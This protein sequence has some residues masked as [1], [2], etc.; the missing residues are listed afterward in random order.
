M[1]KKELLFT[2]NWEQGFVHTS[3]R[4]GSSV[5]LH[6]IMLGFY[7]TTT[8]GQTTGLHV[9]EGF[10]GFQEYSPDYKF[11]R[12]SI[13]FQVFRNFPIVENKELYLLSTWHHRKVC[14]K[15]F[16]YTGIYGHIEYQVTILSG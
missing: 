7:R 11:Q 10:S 1:E 15:I 12:F 8:A 13:V 16:V 4:G 3:L 14:W 5:R 2:F 6:F 9:L